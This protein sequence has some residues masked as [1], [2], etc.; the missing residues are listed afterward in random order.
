MRAAKAAKDLHQ[1]FQEVVLAFGSTLEDASGTE[2]LE[3][4]LEYVSRTMIPFLK[5]VCQE[6]LTSTP[7]NPSEHIGGFLLEKCAAPPTLLEQISSWKKTAA[8]GIVNPLH[9]SPTP[10]E[11]ESPKA[12]RPTGCRFSKGNSFL[13]PQDPLTKRRG[14]AAE[15]QK[16]QLDKLSQSKV[17]VWGKETESSDE[18]GRKPKK[19]PTFTEEEVGK[20]DYVEGEGALKSFM[21]SSAHAGPSRLEDRKKRFTVVYNNTDLPMPPDEEVLALLRNVPSLQGLSDASLTKV[22]G[23][24]ACRRYQADEDIV[25]LNAVSD[26]LHIML[27]GSGA[28]AVP[29]KIGTVTRGS[30]F[31]NTQL[32][33]ITHPS[34]QQIYAYAGPVTTISIGMQELAELQLRTHFID[35]S[36]Q[37]R[38]A[39]NFTSLEDARA[40][41]MSSGVC[42]ATF[43]PIVT[44][45]KLS[46][47][48]RKEII[49][50]VK[51]N[52]VLGELLNLLDNQ[53][54][55][56]ADSMH[57]IQ[58]SSGEVVITKD[59]RGDTLFVV[60][61]GHLEC[62][63]DP[64]LPGDFKIRQG[65]AFGELGL[66][67]D[68]PRSVTVTAAC[69]CRLWVL[70]RRDF[71]VVMQET[72]AQKVAKYSEMFAKVS[73]LANS[74]DARYMDV[75]A[76]VVEELSVLEAEDI[77]VAGED[78]GMLFVLFEGE[79]EVTQDGEPTRIIK[80][81]DFIG[82]EQLE[83]GI[84]AEV[85]MTVTSEVAIVLV[86]D[87]N[88]LSLARS[89]ISSMTRKRGS[90]SSAD[91]DSTMNQDQ[92]AKV[93]NSLL[94]TKMKKA[95]NQKKM[96]K[97]RGSD[98]GES[99]MLDFH[100]DKIKVLG[101]L[102]EGS[103]GRVVLMENTRTNKLLA[104]KALS[105]EQIVKENLG[106]MVKNERNIMVLLDSDF[107]VRLIQSFQDGE[108]IYFVVEPVLCGELFDVYSDRELY[109]NL[110]C[111]KFYI[112]CVALGLEHMHDRHVI[113]RDLKLENCLL[114]ERGYVKLTD[115]GIA[116]VV[117]GK[118]YTVCGTADYFAPETLRQH[119]H[120]RAADWWAC[121]VLLFIMCS[122]RSPFDA[123][124]VQQIY[125]NI[126]KGFSKVKFP[127]NLPSDL[128]DTIKSLCRKV[129][130]ERI[131]MQKGGVANLKEMP[132]FKKSIDWEKLQAREAEPPL[133][134]GGINY[135][136]IKKKKLSKELVLDFDDIE[137]W[138][139]VFEV[140]HASSSQ[141]G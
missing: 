70:T 52:Q 51:T 13:Q 82:E 97:G 62:T 29:H 113:W 45:Y 104:A 100:N 39:R 63:L 122:G 129:P 93:T 44:D 118:T 57:L 75:V 18:Q 49:Q 85:T 12:K 107:I 101:A 108:C 31:G 71:Q 141:E 37:D 102:G 80:A 134:P 36:R 77:C 103:F 46:D 66:L 61:E 25:P 50:A 132:F 112:A 115:M 42:P 1:D 92:K 69:D 20:E 5:L 3:F 6:V 33:P 128:V 78:Q 22:I 8:D 9:L 125:K 91:A 7:G 43:F 4:S 32:K 136:A 23:K 124:E 54:E 120:N 109:G 26:R 95:A 131:P 99:L 14:S 114:D 55:K 27:N 48:D 94:A 21:K 79:C 2:G 17:V 34:T 53:Y 40:Q 116:K 133:K 137:N 127:D 130:E 68:A 19:A 76:G 139:G 35:K 72:H 84:E 89:A 11:G 24:C 64:T 86:L 41:S 56:I 10:P 28:I 106:A 140:T 90:E 98:I 74:I 38:V 105:K 15:L 83:K 73:Y 126:I 123:P 65:T 135:E 30:Y 96:S 58:V 60:H 47:A 81:G 121:G 138:D 119:G 16:E 88:A 59:T 117:I 110:E 111:A 67:Y 87:S